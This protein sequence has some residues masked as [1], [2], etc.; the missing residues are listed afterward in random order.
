MK[1]AATPPATFAKGSHL[2][3]IH[4]LARVVS[5]AL[6][7]FWGAFFLEHLWE[8]FIKPIPNT[9]PVSVW[10]GQVL[11]FL[12]LVG[13]VIG[14]KW[15]A[16]GA[17]IVTVASIL[18]LVDKAPG[19]IPVSILPALLYLYCWHIERHTRQKSRLRDCFH[20]HD[21]LVRR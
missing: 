13:L 1:L 5:A 15:E 9:P 3:A 7:A 14:F 2:E 20:R 4:L 16:A 19:F 8:W 17:A 18:F 12:I 6:L 21:S 11:H 10:I